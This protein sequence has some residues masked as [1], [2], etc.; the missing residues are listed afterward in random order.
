MTNSIRDKSPNDIPL[1]RYNHEHIERKWQDIWVKDHLYKTAIPT[2]EDKTFYALSMFPYPSGTLHMGHVRNYVITDVIARSKRMHGYL[3]LHPMGWDAFGLPAENAAI[4]RG[5]DP[6]KWTKKNIQQMKYQLNQLGLS[7]DWSKELNTSEKDYYKWTQYIFLELFKKGLAYQK[8]ATVNWDPIDKTVL[9]NEQV[10][11]DGKSWRSGVKVEKRKLKQWFL[12]ITQYAEQLEKDLKE[13][14]GWPDKV[15]TMQSNWIGKSIGCEITFISTNS[16]SYRINVFT[17]RPDT[18]Y[19]VKYIVLAPNHELVD[20][21][22]SKKLKSNLKKF[23]SELKSLSEKELSDIKRPK[24]G[25]DLGAFVLNPIN[26]E[27]IPIWI[28]DYV[29]S[30]YGTGAVMG[31]PAHDDRDFL[32]AN[33]YNLPIK[34]VVKKVGSE[35]IT[36]EKAFTEYGV[37]INSGEHNGLASN[38]A[39]KIIIELGNKEGWAKKRIQYKLRD[40]LVSRQRY[41]G[42]PIPIIHCKKCGIVPVPK[43]ELPVELPENVNIS[44]KGNSPLVEDINW[45]KVIC[46]NCGENAK[47]ETDTM[48][49]FICSSW[50]FLRYADSLNTKLPFSNN[51]ISKWLPVDQYVGGIEHAILHLLYSRFITKALNKSNLIHI[52]EPFKKLLTQGMV[53]GI[54]YKNPSNNR[55]IPLDNIKDIKSPKDPETNEKLEIIYEK[56]SKSKYN[57]IEPSKV[58]NRFGADTARMFILFKAPPEKDLEWDDSDVEGQY[59]FIQKIYK[60]FSIYINENKNELSSF[61]KNQTKLELEKLTSTD[62]RLRKATHKAIYEITKDLNNLQFNTAISELMMLLNTI[63][64]LI[65]SSTKI[66]AFESLITFNKLLAPFAPHL[67]EELWELISGK[68]SIHS[69][70]WPIFDEKAIKEKSY[71]LVIQING[72]VRGQINIKNDTTKEEIE[73]IVLE[74]EIS[75][76]WV[77]KDEIKRIIIVPGKLMNIVI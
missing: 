1:D 72:K 15:K 26:N 35:Q 62:L 65:Y 31:V 47:R 20:K 69:Q 48:D 12:S 49:T 56:M 14:K 39:K 10:D 9:A 76:R 50:Y 5:I 22:V 66:V 27:K 33:T 71:N 70:N 32:F 3:V 60:I 38:E 36:K 57:G 58:I 61:H 64:D 2:H 24:K 40:W 34:Y 68:D 63:S 6:S 37:L 53:Q 29:L 16:Q 18:L 73:S 77:K 51:L 59:R 75:K 30:E 52:K 74:T 4:E 44:G 19:G 54:T 11:S 41:W 55:Y 45:K 28:A 42:C 7:V 67:S 13:L 17:T 23:R 46:P 25:F 43:S 21:L 8:E